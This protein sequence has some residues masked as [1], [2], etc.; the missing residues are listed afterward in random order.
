MITHQST[1]VSEVVFQIHASSHG[2]CR[3]GWFGWDVVWCSVCG[4]GSSW[5]AWSQLQA[6][7]RI[8]GCT[9]TIAIHAVT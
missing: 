2:M 9:R 5:R 7:G 3:E 6:V 8:E 1:C 4:G